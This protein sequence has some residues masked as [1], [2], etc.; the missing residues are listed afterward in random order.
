M[1]VVL[2][3]VLASS[4][5]LMLFSSLSMLPVTGLHSIRTEYTRKHTNTCLFIHLFGENINI[6]CQQQKTG[7]RFRSPVSW[8]CG[9][10]FITCSK[11]CSLLVVAV[12]LPVGL[13]PQAFPDWLQSMWQ[14]PGVLVQ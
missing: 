14:A 4:I 6:L 10:Y 7:K 9:R 12:P 13:L 8:P 1:L 5:M 2:P 11:N 3:Y